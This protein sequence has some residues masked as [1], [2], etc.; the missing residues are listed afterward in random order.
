MELEDDMWFLVI[1][2]TLVLA[3]RLHVGFKEA[4]KEIIEES[5]RQD[6]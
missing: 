6:R 4:A 1:I 5:R 3:W 2:C